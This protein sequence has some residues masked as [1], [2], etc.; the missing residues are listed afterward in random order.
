MHGLRLVLLGGCYVL[1]GAFSRHS[2]TIV[3]TR[4]HLFGNLF[5]KKDP[6]NA[7]IAVKPVV[8]Y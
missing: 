1:A 8:K 3:D 6:A 7:A 5:N 2:P 4:L